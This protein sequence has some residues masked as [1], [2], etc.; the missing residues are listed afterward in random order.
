MTCEHLRPL[1]DERRA[2]QLLF[3]LGENPARAHVP[4]VV[5][6]MVR[7]RRLTVLSKPDGGVRGIV[8]GDVIRRL[9][10]RTIAQQLGPAV[11]SATAPHQYALST[12]ARCECITHALQGLCELNP[13]ATVTSIDGVGAYDSISR[14]GHADRA[15]TGGRRRFHATICAH[16]LR[17]PITVF[18]GL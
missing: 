8:S 7:S 1:V 11:K 15:G 6:S 3:K 13:S 14:K 16:V 2:M 18:V 5:E 4:Q 9:V 10:A 12:R 17:I